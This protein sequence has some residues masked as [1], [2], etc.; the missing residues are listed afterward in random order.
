MVEKRKSKDICKMSK[1]DAKLAYAVLRG[2]LEEIDFFVKKGANVFSEVEGIEGYKKG[3]TVWDV[4]HADQKLGGK[5]S[6]VIALT[7]VKAYMEAEG[8]IDKEP[9]EVLKEIHEKL[10]RRRKMKKIQAS[11]D[12][13]LRATTSKKE[14]KKTGSKKSKTPEK[15]KMTPPQFVNNTQKYVEIRPGDIAQINIPPL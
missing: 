2:D 4:L 7:L 12:D 3:D 1:V 13:Y 15:K 6:A 14:K 9:A 11:K 5:S 8:I 10:L